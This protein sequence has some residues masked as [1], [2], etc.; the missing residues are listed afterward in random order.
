MAQQT[1][2][3]IIEEFFPKSNKHDW[4]KIATRETQKKNPLESLA[5]HGKDNILFL[6]YYDQD[7]ID[8][9][10]SFTTSQN[11]SPLQGHNSRTWINLP[12]IGHADER[13][14]NAR[15]LEHLSAGADGVLFDLWQAPNA[16]MHHLLHEIQLAHCFTAFRIPSDVNFLPAFS[17]YLKEMSAP[18]WIN[19][20]LFWESIPKKGDW[21]M[22][23]RDCHNFCALGITIPP[24]SPVREIA[25]A[26]AT[27]VSII[28]DLSGSYP[29]ASIFNSICF[30]L[31]A[32]A[33]LFESI[34]KYRALRLLW[35]QVAHAYGQKN[36]NVADL[37][38]HACSPA[39]P[40]GAYAPHE[41]MLKGTFSA[42]AA[43]L[44]GCSSLTVEVVDADH[45][46]LARWGRNV[47]NI[48]REESFFG[49]ATDP[50]AGAY[51]LDRITESIAR[52]AWSLF[53]Q[54][55]GRL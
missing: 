43:L 22:L 8:R 42:M 50:A 55:T 16:S 23:L 54:N 17:A 41:N 19:G 34:A 51:A 52:T 47:S 44:G 2:D 40:D 39:V 18:A 14:A 13:T 5:W 25:D 48:L 11:T 32:D 4:E 21:N 1:I 10:D 15:A 31:S 37:H 36:Y 38:L 9:A 30:S 49:A 35:Y 28:E 20:A 7:D 12:L 24:S 27:G 46:A 29:V 3:R 26:L 6:P 33:L 45:P 53:Q